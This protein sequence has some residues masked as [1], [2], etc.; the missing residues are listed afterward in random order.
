MDHFRIASELA[1]GKTPT[2]LEYDRLRAH[3]CRHI[4]QQFSADRAEAE[5]MVDEALTRFV[6]AAAAGRV[7][8]E[9][10]LPYLRR[11]VKN[12]AIDRARK[13]RDDLVESLA[14]YPAN[15]DS[16]ARLVDSTA[17][18]ALVE[19]A[20]MLAARRKDTGCTAVANEWLREAA[21]QGMSPS[22]REVARRV[23]TSH[24]TVQ[25]ALRRLRG[26][27]QEILGADPGC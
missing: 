11:I 4:C 7:Q 14:E 12:E 25:K 24:V 23:N 18:A 21:R 3:L 19:A 13:R 10:A 22:S 20:L 15:D 2:A 27:M 1:A 16:I 6:T 5:D 8:Q 9:T 26:Y 17:S